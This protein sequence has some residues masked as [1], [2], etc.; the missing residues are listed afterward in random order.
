M[1]VVF[2]KQIGLASYTTKTVICHLFPQ[3]RGKDQNTQ[4]QG[5]TNHLHEEHMH[6]P[7]Q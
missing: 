1:D 2:A 6:L 7:E 5:Q 4:I 3:K